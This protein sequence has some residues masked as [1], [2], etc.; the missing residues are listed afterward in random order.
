MLVNSCTTNTFSVD[1]THNAAALRYY[2]TEIPQVKSNSL[3]MVCFWKKPRVHIFLKGQVT[4]QWVGFCIEKNYLGPCLSK[5]P[6]G[7][8]DCLTVHL[9]LHTSLCYT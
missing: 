1:L 2:N 4:P 3:M 7:V 9:W 5:T 6:S 8:T